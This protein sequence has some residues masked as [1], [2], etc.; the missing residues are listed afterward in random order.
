MTQNEGPN[1]PDWNGSSSAWKGK[2]D[3]SGVTG[4]LT[5]P[6]SL[7]VET[8]NGSIDSWVSDT[9][10]LLYGPGGDPDRIF[11]AA[12]SKCYLLVPIAAPPNLPNEANIVTMACF[13]VYDGGNAFDKWRGVLVPI[14]R[15]TCNYGVF[16]PSWT[17]TAGN[18]FSETQVML[19]S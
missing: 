12:A 13:K 4:P 18:G 6:F 17:W 19:T 14:T 5:P 3:I 11:T 1:C 8:G 2:V 9:C 10:I 7:P 15:D 16:V